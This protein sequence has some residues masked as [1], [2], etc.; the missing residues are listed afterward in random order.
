MEKSNAKKKVSKKKAEFESGSESELN[1]ENEDTF[2]YTEV[3]PPSF[4]AGRRKDL[5]FYIDFHDGYAFRQIMEFLKLTVTSVPMYFT[6]NSISILQGN[7]DGSLVVSIEIKGQELLTYYFNPELANSP[8]RKEMGLVPLVPSSNSSV[9]SSSS[10]SSSTSDKPCHIVCFN[11]SKFR[12]TIKSTARKEG[13]RIFQYADD[14]TV[15]IQVYG[16][17]KNGEGGTSIETQTYSRM[18]Y[19]LTGFEQSI[20][21]PNCK[22]PLSEF[23]NSCGHFGKVKSTKYT[24]FTC[25][26]SGVKVTACSETGVISMFKKWGECEDDSDHPFRNTGPKMKIMDST[27]SGIVH[28]VKIPIDIVK[29][30]SKLS[31]LTNN[32]II[33]IY[34]EEDKIIRFMVSVSYYAELV[35]YWKEPEGD[36]V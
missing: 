30:L 27:K 29:A 22:S 26:K 15:H 4:A 34:C 19:D 14:P 6:D 28:N 25:Y 24:N 8:V 13:I 7:G 12:D 36:F 11:V 35:I 21:M 2:Q 20:L 18:N 17:N 31:N 33:R 23:C 10:S 9:S 16:G 3:P 5:V 1:S 32:G